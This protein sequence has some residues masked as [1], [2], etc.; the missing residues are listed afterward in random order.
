MPNRTLMRA[1]ALLTGVALV[2]L[3][4]CRSVLEH[5][6]ERPEV[7]LRGVRM[8]QMGLLSQQTEIALQLKN[9]NPVP[10][11]VKAVRY[12]IVLAGLQVANGETT[13]AFTVPAKGETDINLLVR[14]NALQLAAQAA[15]LAANFNGRIDYEING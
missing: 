2:M 12:K 4:G 9:P 8:T 10:L 11:P 6:L 7:S 1:A 5:T 13:D 14:T 3:L 15:N